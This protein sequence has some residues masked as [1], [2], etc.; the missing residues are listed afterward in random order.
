M[1]NNYEDLTLYFAEEIYNNADEQCNDIYKQQKQDQES[2]LD[3]IAKVLLGYTILDTVLSLADNEKIKLRKEFSD[4]INSISA[5]Q[6]KEEKNVMNN[7]FELSTKDKYYSDAY[8]M[9][10][11]V[12]FKLKKLSEKQIKEVVNST[13]D[14]ELWSSRLWSNKKELEKTL[15][16]EIEKFLNGTTNVNEIQKVV[17]N[18]FNQNAFNTRRLVQ[19]EVARCQNQANDVFAQEHGIEE[20]MFTATLDSKTSDFC[21]SHD[22]IIYKIDDP[23]KP[24]IPAHPFCR[25]CYINVPTNEWKPTYRKNNITKEDIDYKT[26][27]E[28]LEEQDI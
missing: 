5:G 1:D 26:Y 25:S 17:K 22:G 20:Q 27:Q 13:I 14:S 18:K 16:V 3:K 15:K 6:F 4:I 24:H 11:G 8:T 10:I 7:I 12:N 2:L 21:R 23:N 19:T 9:D 28:W